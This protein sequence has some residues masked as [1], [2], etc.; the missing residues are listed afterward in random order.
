MRDIPERFEACD[1]S[2]IRLE[3]EFVPISRRI[4]AIYTTNSNAKTFEDVMRETPELALGS[5]DWL[6]RNTRES[7]EKNADIWAE[8]AEY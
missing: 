5:E 8:L 1:T 4:E 2:L 7:I 3:I 6:R